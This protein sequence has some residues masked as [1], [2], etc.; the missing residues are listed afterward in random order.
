MGSAEEEIFDIGTRMFM[1]WGLDMATSKIISVL[2]FSP[3]ELSSQE[4]S[5]KTGYSLATIHNK[6]KMFEAAAV[7]QKIS[8]PGTKRIYYFM[9]KDRVKLLQQKIEKVCNAEEAFCND[10]LL[11][12]LEKYKG[13]KVC[14]K[15]KKMLA[16]MSKFYS[17][18]QEL[19]ALLNEFMQKVSSL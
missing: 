13:K 19:R 8:K 5:E 2:L 3:G 6:L 1:T 14:A 11:P 10:N 16:I 12:L 15:E 4:L 17:Q 7:V 18:S 9:E